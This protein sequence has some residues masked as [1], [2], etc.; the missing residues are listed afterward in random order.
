MTSGSYAL[1]ALVYGR[2][3]RRFEHPRVLTIGLSLMGVGFLLLW[4]TG[5]WALILL[6][7]LLPGAGQ[8]LLIPYLSVWLSDETTAALRGRALGGLTTVLF[9]GASISP[10]VGQP[11][12][13]V[14]GFRG[15][16][17]AAGVLLLVSAAYVR[18]VRMLSASG[19]VPQERKKARRG[20]G[21][22]PE[23]ASQDGPVAL[24][25]PLGAPRARTQRLWLRSP[26]VEPPL[27]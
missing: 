17:A 12:N 27:P 23:A 9:L 4:A 15:V 22:G 10:L 20:P 3:G 1:A 2:V 8:G 24:G 25:P 14:A 6:G 16:S 19:S 13:A 21:E 7:L 26:P 18:R 11:L 5:G